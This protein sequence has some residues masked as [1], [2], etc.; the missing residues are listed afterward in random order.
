MKIVLEVWM[1]TKNIKNGKYVCTYKNLIP[2]FFSLLKSQ[3]WLFEAKIMRVYGITQG[4]RTR[5]RTVAQILGER[6]PK[7]WIL[8]SKW[9]YTPWRQYILLS[10][11]ATTKITE[12]QL[13]SRR[14]NRVIN[15]ILLTQKKMEK[16]NRTDRLNRKTSMNM[17]HLNPTTQML[18]V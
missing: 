6:G 10:P 17:V 15:S 8:F 7:G 14:E 16:G 18:M 12:I 9:Y 13:I 2:M 1:Y 11:K 4:E 5:M 3:W